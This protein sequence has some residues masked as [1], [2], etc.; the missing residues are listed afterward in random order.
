MDRR[1]INSN[2]GFAGAM[3]VIAVAVVVGV[4]IIGAVTKMGTLNK[5]YDKSRAFFDSELAIETFAVSLKNAYDKANYLQDTPPQTGG[6]PANDDYG[7]PGKIVTIGSGS[8]QIRLCWEYAKGLCS[9]RSLNAGVDIC[10]DASSL[11]VSQIKNDEWMVAVETTTNKEDRIHKFQAATYELLKKLSFPT[12]EAALDSFMP[13]IPAAT[14]INTFAINTG[15]PNKPDELTCET[16]S[17]QCL[18]VSFC[19]KNGST[20]SNE[21]LIRQTYIFAVPAKT[22]Q[23]Y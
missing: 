20:C 16:A 8:K 21:E 14:P 22:T 13:S 23:G 19:V 6:T 3:L 12:A 1:F 4:I 5:T 7:C 18:K 10:I 11:K 9:K 15:F 17:Y 2:K